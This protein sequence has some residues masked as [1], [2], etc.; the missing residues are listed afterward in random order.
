MAVDPNDIIEI[1]IGSFMA[2][3]LVG[4]RPLLVRFQGDPEFD[5]IVEDETGIYLIIETE[6]SDYI[7]V[8]F[9]HN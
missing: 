6:D 2:D 7:I 5:V 1:F 8:E 9:E 3:P 4:R